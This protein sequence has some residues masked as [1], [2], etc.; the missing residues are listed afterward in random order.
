MA[1][2]QAQVT[3]PFELGM[4]MLRP[5]EVTSEG[6]P[7]ARRGYDRGYVDRLLQRTAEAYALT[8]K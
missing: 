7:L 3:K 2:E 4:S 5:D 1:A 8:L 6:L